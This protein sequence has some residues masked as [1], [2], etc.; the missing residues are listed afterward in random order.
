MTGAQRCPRLLVQLVQGLAE[1]IDLAAAAVVET[2]KN[3]QQRGLSRAGLANQGDALAPF[4]KQLNSGKDGEF[5]LPLTDGLLKMMNFKYVF[6]W[7]LPFLCLILL[8][9]RAA[10]ADTLLVLGD[11][12]SAGYRMAATSAWPA[13]LNE[14][15]QPKT[16]IVNGSISGDTAQQGLARL[17]A[18]LEQHHPRWVLVELGGNDGLRG[19]PPAQL[20]QTLD[21]VIST[22]QAAGAEPLLMQIRL[23]A[24]YGRRYTASFSAIY[25]ELAQ[26]HSIPL[27]PFFMEQVY[28]KPQWMQ[29]DGIHPNP[30]AQ[31]F[32]ADWMASRLAPIVK[33]GGE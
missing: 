10:A 9:C 7:H 2:G 16:R 11:S 3:R 18:L 25:P 29:D 21:K 32:I 6:R 13:L 28:L 24:N 19:F 14:K 20:K 31:P 4:D 22:V 27:L 30:D 1:E 17:P 8:T 15:W 12:L 26:Q 33:H 5:L 23:P